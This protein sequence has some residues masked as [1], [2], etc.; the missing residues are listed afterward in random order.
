[1]NKILEAIK[2]VNC[3]NLLESPVFLPCGCLICLKHTRD[4]KEPNLLCCSCEIDHPLPSNGNFPPNQ[5]AIKILAAKINTLEF[6]NEHKKAKKSCD[7]LEE[8]LNTI[9]CLL[10]DPFNFA[11]DAIEH[12]KNETQ[13]KVDK[14]KLKFDDEF[15]FLIP[16]LDD[17]H[18]LL[19]TQLD[20]YKTSCKVNLKSSEYLVKSSEFEKAKEE[21]R[22]EL[23]KWLSTLN[24]LNQ[25]ENNWREIKSESEKR[26][27]H[28]RFE[29]AK[30]KAE[31][32]LQKQYEE[33]EDE[34]GRKFGKI[35][36]D[37]NY[38]FSR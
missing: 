3:R 35:R 11:Y 36:V 28:F 15:A 26:I 25:N 2:C 10:K 19:I 23:E 7:Q 27:E 21:A 6:G 29:L 13:L 20:D 33:Y 30:F 22:N 32:L 8:L 12:L 14:L 37:L 4:V 5:V 24:E 9:D 18:T 34:I 16:A 31:S 38:K 1:M 17:D